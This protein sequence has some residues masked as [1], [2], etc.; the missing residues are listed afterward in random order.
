MVHLGRWQ[1]S[2][3]VVDEGDSEQLKTRR[4]ELSDCLDLFRWR[5]DPLTLKMSIHSTPLEYGPHEEWFL[6]SLQ[7]PLRMIFIVQNR[8]GEKVG[9]TRFDVN[10]E[11]RVATVSINLN[12]EF[13][14]KKLSSLVLDLSCKSFFA[15]GKKMDLEAV[16]RFDNQASIRCFQQCGFEK[17]VS[18]SGFY[19]FHKTGIENGH[20]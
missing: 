4:A 3:V 12:P 10:L 7:N 17:Q 6:A 2:A 16:V 13:R 9:M 5:N 1:D 20:P 8:R 14:G 11:R 19:L 18:N 15:S